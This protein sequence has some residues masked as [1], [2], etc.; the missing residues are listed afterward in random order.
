[1]KGPRIVYE[2]PRGCF[3]NE[4]FEKVS[5]YVITEESMSERILSVS[6]SSTL[7]VSYP[8]RLTGAQYGRNALL[9]TLGFLL[10]PKSPRSFREEV[11]PM[12]AKIGKFAK[13][14]ET[15]R[16]AISSSSTK[17]W[18]SALLEKVFV[19]LNGNKRSYFILDFDDLLEEATVKDSKDSK[20]KRRRRRRK[21]RKKSR[22]DA[23]DF[24]DDAFTIDT[25]SGTKHEISRI[26]LYRIPWYTLNRQCSEKDDDIKDHHVPILLDTRT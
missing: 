25:R 3:P 15:E 21:G 9:F 19:K 14:M 11:K 24:E 5:N 16:E 23:D 2:Y 13:R 18:I 22:E 8:V 1:M 26:G 10:S 7:V 4:M 6:T 17:V 12:L 20:D